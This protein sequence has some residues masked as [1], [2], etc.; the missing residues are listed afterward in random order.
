MA[1]IPFCNMYTFISTK[2]A[3]NNSELISLVKINCFSN[4]ENQLS[5]AKI[6]I[7]QH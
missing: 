2:H 5:M 4:I 7:V 3:Q 6:V 1:A